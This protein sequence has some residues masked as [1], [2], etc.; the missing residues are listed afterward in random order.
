MHYVFGEKTFPGLKNKP[1]P[2]KKVF[3]DLSEFRGATFFA[4]K[5]VRL[6]KIS[7]KVFSDL[8]S[9]FR[10]ATFFAKKCVPASKNKPKPNEKVF[11]DLSSKFRGA[12][13]FAKKCVRLQKISP[14][15]TKK[16]FGP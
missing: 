12:T 14:D 5:C 3:S 13:F 7:P 16:F 15:Q 11:S 10:G 1:R 8:S 2:K 4:K 6:Q 9:T